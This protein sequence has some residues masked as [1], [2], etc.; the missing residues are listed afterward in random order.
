MVVKAPAFDILMQMLFLYRLCMSSA[1]RIS[2][3]ENAYVVRKDVFTTW[4]KIKQRQS[5]AH[6][7]VTL[8]FIIFY[9][10]FYIPILIFSKL[11]LKKFYSNHVVVRSYLHKWWDHMDFTY[12]FFKYDDTTHVSTIEFSINLILQLAKHE[13]ISKEV[14]WITW[15]GQYL[16]SEMVGWSGEL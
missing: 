11:I 10:L 13:L 16:R 1:N 8:I 14:V 3:A 4:T 7:H 9:F 6:L 2:F 12:H 5:R 15:V